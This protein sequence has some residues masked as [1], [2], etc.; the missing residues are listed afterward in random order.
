MVIGVTMRLW[1]EPPETS[2]DAS[3]QGLEPLCDPTE[4]ARAVAQAL[5]IP[6]HVI[7][8]RL[9]F[10]QHVV[11]T[12]IAEYSAGRT[13]NPCLYCNRY[14]KFGHLLQEANRLG[15]RRLATGHYARVRLGA[16]GQTWELLR[17]VDKRKDQSYV[18]YMLQQGQLRRTLFPLGDLTKVQVRE[19]ARERHLPSAETQES[20][21]LCFIPDNDY[22]RFL[23]RYAPQALAPGP[24]LD[25]AGRELGRHKGLAAYT[26]GQRS[27]MGIA[28]PEALYVIEMDVERNALIVGPKRV[29]GRSDLT[30]LDVNWIC[31]V[32]PDASIQATVKIRYRARLVPALVTPLPEARA[33]V[34]LDEPLR[35]ITPGQ[36][37]VFYNGET[38]LGG[39]LIGS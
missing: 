15:C 11:A 26:I 19:M 34:S 6:F 36:G 33:H 38:V 9:P 4:R 29:L 27:G 10:R 28:A 14:V 31:G 24:I 32:P 8:A 2:D 17:G 21:D 37:V 22:R 16:D 20:Q 1:Q 39:G 30:V 35:D 12:F 3:L 23:Q 18:L 5:D 25:Q 13:P 7:D